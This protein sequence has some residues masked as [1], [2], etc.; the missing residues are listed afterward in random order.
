MYALLSASPGRS[1]YEEDSRCPLG[2]SVVRE[3]KPGDEVASI[4]HERG[5]PVAVLIEYQAL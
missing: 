4:I 3:L 1:T 5:Q 2:R